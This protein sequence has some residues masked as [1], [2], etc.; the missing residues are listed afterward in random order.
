MNSV[1]F[2]DCLRSTSIVRQFLH[3]SVV[4]ITRHPVLCDSHFEENC[5]R[6]VRHRDCSE[7]GRW[8]QMSP[9]IV[10]I[11]PCPLRTLCDLFVSAVSFMTSERSPQRRRDRR[12]GAETSWMPSSMVSNGVGPASA[13][14]ER[15]VALT[16]WHWRLLALFLADLRSLMLVA[17][18]GSSPIISV[19]CWAR[20]RWVST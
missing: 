2:T 9:V 16:T 20:M 3:S 1:Y 8:R 10:R 15:S 4:K 12:E 6:I 5:V 13:V 19:R 18:M 11:S 14:V 7:Q 17:A